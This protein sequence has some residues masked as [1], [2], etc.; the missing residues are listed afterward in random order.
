MGQSGLE[1]KNVSMGRAT[2][3]RKDQEDTLKF[4]FKEGKQGGGVETWPNQVSCKFQVGRMK[5]SRPRMIKLAN[6]S[7]YS[8][9]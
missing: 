8:I 9:D 3:S 5:G 1:S 2:K 6:E 4:T 7:S